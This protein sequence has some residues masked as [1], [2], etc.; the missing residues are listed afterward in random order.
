MANEVSNPPLFEV[1][2]SGYRTDLTLRDLF[3]LGALVGLL[4]NPNSDGDGMDFARASYK[5]ADDM[6]AERAMK[7]S[8]A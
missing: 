6:L 1:R 8:K 5:Y 3:A 4:S 2:V 7:E